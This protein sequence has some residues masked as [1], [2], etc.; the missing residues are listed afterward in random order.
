MVE[1]NDIVKKAS[2][3]VFEQFKTKLPHTH[4]Y[5]QYNHTA[6]IV[7][8]VRKIGEG[9]KLSDT[10]MEI[11][12]LA[13]LFHDIGYTETNNGHEEKGVEIATR[14]LEEHGYPKERMEKVAGCIL[15]TKMPQS[16]N[17]MME[18]VLADADLNHLGKKSF[19]EKS[20]LIRVE[21]EKIKGILYTDYEWVKLN[22]DF[23][24]QHQFHT[25][26]ARAKYNEQRQENILVLQRKLR[27]L[28]FEK[29]KED[30][31][32]AERKAKNEAKVEK[33]KAPDR[34]VET[35]F[36]VSSKNH[37]DLSSIADHKANMMIQI[38]TLLIG[39]VV[40]LLVR[41]LDENPELMIPTFILLVFCL[42]ATVFAILSTRPKITAGKFTREDIK[43][44]KANL[45]FFGNFYRMNLE[46]YDWGMKE[47][48]RDSEYLY[49]SMTKDIYFLGKVL[50]RK[51][52]LLR[53]SY[54]VF[55]Y[56]MIASIIAYAIA[57]LLT[58]H[59]PM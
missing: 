59:P 38:N 54:D 21:R 26:H 34:G 20:D 28:T 50:G 23:I 5:H 14:F 55:M 46:D 15:A 37:M 32:L 29:E 47:M 22:A 44:K 12:S 43:Q 3:Y 40:S 13:A 16:P 53:I 39:A 36:R 8:A 1:S 17:N 6:E 41:K 19:F 11:V 2:E 7:D 30:E 25:K 35:M 18:E 10:E 45:L 31:K 52:M 51:F 33:D 4:V 24:T 58:P 56:G 49:G 57:V 42:T 9:S 27:E 48:M